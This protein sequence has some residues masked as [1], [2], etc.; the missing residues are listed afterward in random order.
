MRWLGWEDCFAKLRSVYSKYQCKSKRAAMAKK[1]AAICGSLRK[2]SYNM[3]ILKIVCKKL[4]EMGHEVTLIDINDYDVPLFSQDIETTTG[5]PE[6]VKVMKGIVHSAQAIVIATPEYN[7]SVSGVGKNAID[8]ISRPVTPDEGQYA[9]FSGKPAGIIAASP[10]R[11]G[12]VRA[13]THLRH[14]L[15]VLGCNVMGKQVIVPEAHKM[16]EVSQKELETFATM[17][18]TFIGKLLA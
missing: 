14:I 11:L 12:G 1:I 5:M 9:S 4:S 17:F 6:K 13:L 8:W 15:S 2:D 10:G 16:N 7:G 18:D 3:A